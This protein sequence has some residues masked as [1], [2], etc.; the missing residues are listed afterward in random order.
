MK[1]ISR[2][3]TFERSDSE[4]VSESALKG[5]APSTARKKGKPR[6]CHCA[7]ADRLQSRVFSLVLDGVN[8]GAS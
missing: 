5:E 3:K 7:A 4:R 1:G 2:E 8:A 6:S